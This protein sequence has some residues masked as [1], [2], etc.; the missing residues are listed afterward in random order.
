MVK[1]RFKSF[2]GGR[3]IDDYEPLEFDLEDE[4]FV[5]KPAV[6]GAVLLE[7]VAAADS[8]SGGKSA[9]A[10]YDFFKECMDEVE[11]RRFDEYLKNPKMIFDFEVLGDIAGFLVE[12]YTTRPTQPSKSSSDGPSS[13]GRMSTG[14]ESLQESD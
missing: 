1:R 12:E 11:Y 2:T 10:L 13:S 4:T 8:D 3:N 9:Q 5:C 7:F 6:Q 14:R